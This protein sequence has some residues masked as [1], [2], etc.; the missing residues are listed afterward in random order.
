MERTSIFIGFTP[1]HAYV[2]GSILEQVSGPIYCAFT[3][4]WPVTTN[5]YIRLAPS[6]AWPTPARLAICLFRLTTTVRK[7]VARGHPLDVYI[8]HPSHIMS[9]YLFFAEIPGKRIYLYEDGLLNYHDAIPYKPFVSTTKRLLAYFTGL[10]YRDYPGH[11]AGYDVG[12]YDGAFLSAPERA[13]RKE[14]LGE[15]R[16]LLFPVQSL[17]LKKKQF[18]S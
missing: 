5:R 8:P 11:V 17:Q 2:A 4:M 6:D 15:I 14:R 3:K 9:N 7:L 1:Y 18:C 16:R 10:N 13:V 12:S